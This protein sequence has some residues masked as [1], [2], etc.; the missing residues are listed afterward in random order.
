MGTPSF[1]GSISDTPPLGPTVSPTASSVDIVQD[2]ADKRAAYDSALA[3]YNVAKAPYDILVSDLNTLSGNITFDVNN[4]DVNALNAARAALLTASTDYVTSLAYWQVD[5]AQKASATT[6]QE[7]TSLLSD[8]SLTQ[9]QIA[10][11]TLAQNQIV[12]LQGQM[13]YAFLIYR[14][15]A[16]QSAAEK[17][18][19]D[20]AEVALTMARTEQYTNPSSPVQDEA[21]VENAQ[22][23]YDQTN[24][25]YQQFIN[26]E[27]TDRTSLES[28]L[29]SLTNNYSAIQQFGV[30][31][32]ELPDLISAIKASFSSTSGYAAQEQTTVSLQPVLT[33]GEITIPKP[34]VYR[35]ISMASL[36]SLLATDETTSIQTVQQAAIALAKILALFRQLQIFSFSSLGDLLSNDATSALNAA[37]TQY[38]TTSAQNNADTKTW[39][40]NLYNAYISPDNLAIINQKID[41]ENLA[42]QNG[43][44]TTTALFN[45]AQG[46]QQ[47]V[48]ND[49]NA[50]QLSEDLPDQYLS[51]NAPSAD[52]PTLPT[53]TYTFAQI[54]AQQPVSSSISIDDLNACISAIMT[55]IALFSQDIIP[56]LSLPSGDQYLHPVSM[57]PMATIEAPNSTVTTS[58][59]STQSIAQLF[60]STDVATALTKTD[61]TTGANQ[62]AQAL[63]TLFI[64][65]AMGIKLAS[66]G[67]MSSLFGA[68]ASGGPS[69]LQLSLMAS[70]EEMNNAVT[71]M[72]QTAALLAGLSLV[73]Q[74]QSVL[75]K[76]SSTTM[77]LSEYLESEAQKTG[78]EIDSSTQGQLASQMIQQ[79]NILAND[80]KA[81][82]AY[83]STIL[84]TVPALSALKPEELPGAISEVT[85]LLQ[86]ILLAATVTVAASQGL[87]PDQV[88]KL[89]Y[90][91]STGPNSAL[92][93]LITSLGIPMTKANELASV[94]ADNGESVQAIN[95]LQLDATAKAEILTLTAAQKGNISIVSGVPGG[96]GFLAAMLNDLQSR[97]VS[98]KATLGSQEFLPQLVA[99]LQNVANDQQRTALQALLAP[100]PPAPS[101]TTGSLNDVIASTLKTIG[102]R[103][104]AVAQTPTNFD[105]SVSPVSPRSILNQ[106]TSS[107]STLSPETQKALIDAA[108]SNPLLSGIT[109]LSPEEKASVLALVA[110][111]TVSPKEISSLLSLLNAQTTAE[112]TGAPF[113]L[114]SLQTTLTEKIFRP[115]PNEIRRQEENREEDVTNDQK[116]SAVK[117][118]AK[119]LRDS[120]AATDKFVNI[121]LDPG[122]TI[123]VNFCLR[124]RSSGT[125]GVQPNITLTG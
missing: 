34:S 81:L 61:L 84:Q 102:P 46:I 1:S 35:E 13:L 45:T 69:G 66:G 43:D 48:L 27:A 11:L 110:S 80:P 49:I 29:A 65:L 125:Q 17:N 106:L 44:Q 21:D 119:E 40:I 7:L 19:L 93:S 38:N 87:S 51:A 89:L 111:K 91:P 52:L 109:G 71:Q 50:A 78:Q 74:S 82:Q 88:E 73:G 53:T 68:S 118:I 92:S 108:A 5:T 123:L 104:E 12:T 28:A 3:A 122:M 64:I 41:E 77:T 24:T 98:V 8:P 2:V 63:S 99:Q 42:L 23:F 124:T 32:P 4:F 94:L 103:L 62:D 14:N 96:S 31:A 114:S 112:A 90:G 37:L 100:P 67:T 16:Y 105:T 58:Q 86:N 60:S 26:Q 30:V 33:S 83:A 97:G 20:Q 22:A 70:S 36:A 6:V 56:T 101:P 85:S 120:S 116:K 18:A 121:P 95:S 107:F 55:P 9:D 39:A 113:A 115:G 59:Q 117:T 57:F 79:L 10:T 75:E 54:P 15:D 72:L 76:L 47:S 25:T